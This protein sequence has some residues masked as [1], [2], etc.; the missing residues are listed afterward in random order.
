M[1]T[2]NAI[3]SQDN[4]LSIENGNENNFSVQQAVDT[5]IV[6][7]DSPDIL[8]GTSEDD[9][10]SALAGDDTIIGTTGNDF[11]NGG[12]GLDTA[13]YTDFGEAVTILPAGEFDNNA[14]SQLFSIE[15][16]IGATGQQNTIDGSSVTTSTFINVNLDNNSLIVEDVPV[17]GSINLEV[18]NF[19]KVVGTNNADFITGDDA[20]N[21]LI[22]RAGD[23]EI[24]GGGGNDVLVGNR[25]SDRLNGTDSL[26][27][28]AN[29][30]DILLGGA[31]GD[32]FILGDE[33]GSFYIEGGNSDLAEIRDFSAGDVIELGRGE[34]YSVDRLDSGFNLFAEQDDGRELIA[35]V[36]F[37][38]SNASS[39]SSRSTSQIAA[40]NS[41]SFDSQIELP[42]DSF[43]LDSGESLDIFTGA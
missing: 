21:T 23:D 7:S 36:Q 38:S 6:G 19:V 8:F 2:L 34:T 10:I 33:N 43:Q 30:R 12:D 28:G 29:E 14:D 11:I 24:T 16:I 42:T 32:R 15:R 3:A 4:S 39:I 1:V 27:R 5:D 22:G 26:F 9:T 41:S 18:E 17:I 25:G 35:R 31:Q 20:N 37:P 40:D 13:D